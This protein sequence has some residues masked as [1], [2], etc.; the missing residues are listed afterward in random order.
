MIL[1]ARVVHFIAP[2]HPPET[3]E[4]NLVDVGFLTKAVVG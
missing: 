3:D 4:R 2:P 1:G